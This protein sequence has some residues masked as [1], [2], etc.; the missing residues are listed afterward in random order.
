[1]NVIVLILGILVLGF[2][3]IPNLFVV[4]VRLVKAISSKKS[5]RDETYM[6][7]T[8]IFHDNKKSLLH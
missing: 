3:G 6:C 5:W 7:L 8:F 1:M 2:E 4:V